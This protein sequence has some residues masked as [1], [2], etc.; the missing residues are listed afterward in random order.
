MVKT[1]DMLSVDD[2]AEILG[3]EVIGVVPDDEEII[4]T[5]NRGEPVVLDSTRRLSRL[6]TA[7]ARRVLGENAPLPSLEDDG[8]WNRLR[9]LIGSKAQ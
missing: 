4:D 1:G 7:I 8:I 5:T 3:R 9:R 6:Y 2:V